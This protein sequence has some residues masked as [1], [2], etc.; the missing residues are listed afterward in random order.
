MIIFSNSDEVT[1]EI[2][3]AYIETSK[4]AAK[5]S[6]R[7][8]REP[9]RTSRGEALQMNKLNPSVSNKWNDEGKEMYE[10]A[11]ES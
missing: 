7:K 6:V 11:K 10:R 3:E 8:R 9:S 2:K 1:R 4:Q 5:V